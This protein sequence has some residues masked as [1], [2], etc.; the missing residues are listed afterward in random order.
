MKYFEKTAA[1]MLYMPTY[2]RS[3]KNFLLDKFIP[4]VGSGREFFI[5][6]KNNRVKS[7]LGEAFLGP[8][9]L[10]T[11]ASKINKSVLNDI[12]NN[13]EVLDNESL[14]KSILKGSRSKKLIEQKPDL[15]RT[16]NL[17]KIEKELD[18]LISRERKK[19]LMARIAASSTIPAVGGAGFLLKNELERN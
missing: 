7:I 16:G 9:F 2:G 19:T 17:S 14:L 15:Q 12:S 6:P 10:K 18:D 1:P 13:P 8:L 3:T 5:A 4:F 11:R